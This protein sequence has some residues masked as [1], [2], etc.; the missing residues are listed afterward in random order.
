MK[1]LFGQAFRSQV[2]EFFYQYINNFSP[3]IEIDPF[4]LTLFVNVCAKLLEVLTI[5]K[6][7]VHVTASPH[8]TVTTAHIVTSMIGVTFVFLVLVAV[9]VDFL[10]STFVVLFIQLTQDIND[11]KHVY[12]LLGCDK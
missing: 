4:F 6:L 12:R 8:G 11:D 5:L 1:F 10:P 9:Y 2:N 3:Y 7:F